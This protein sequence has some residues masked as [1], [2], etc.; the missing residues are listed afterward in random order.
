M[1]TPTNPNATGTA[2]NQRPAYS[3]SQMDDYNDVDDAIAV[4]LLNNQTDDDLSFQDAERQTTTEAGGC[5]GVVFA[6]VIV[7]Y[8]ITSFQR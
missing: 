7:A 8:L 2:K 5:F 3:E 1:I 6:L 4:E